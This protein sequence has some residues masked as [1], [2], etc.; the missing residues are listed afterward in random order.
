MSFLKKRGLPASGFW[1]ATGRFRAVGRVAGRRKRG[2]V[3]RSRAK[4][5]PNR[6]AIAGESRRHP[7]LVVSRFDSYRA[8]FGQLSGNAKSCF[9]FSF[10][11]ISL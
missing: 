1:R 3:C 11:T 8:F 7:A 10:R 2:S 5:V 4:N 9:E 6:E